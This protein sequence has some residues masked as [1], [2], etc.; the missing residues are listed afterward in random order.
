M[1]SMLMKSIISRFDNNAFDAFFRRMLDK[2]E[3]YGRTTKRLSN[4]DDK[5]FEC[6]AERFYQSVDTFFLCYS[7]YRLFEKF[8]IDSLDMSSMIN[9]LSK[10]IFNRNFMRDQWLPSDGVTLYV[11]NNFDSDKLGIS[12]MALLE[13]YRKAIRP[14]LQ[15]DN[16]Y[17]V[18]VGNIN[19]FL[20]TEGK[21]TNI[22]D[23]LR[24]FLMGN[25]E[26]ICIG[27]SD[28]KIEASRFF[29]ESEFEGIT[30]K[31]YSIIQPVMKKIAKAEYNAPI[32]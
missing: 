32:G 11:I 27:L 22:Q 6:S 23:V 8:S 3:I 4:I 5:I 31:S 29:V 19:T 25:D 26:G 1:D 17:R 24:S 16:L 14:I 15:N 9:L 30:Q 18:G 28:D 13:H 7:P 12:D 21:H 10:Y 2:S 20:N